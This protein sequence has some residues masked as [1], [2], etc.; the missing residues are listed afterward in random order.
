MPTLLH[1]CMVTGWWNGKYGMQA[2]KPEKLQQ[3]NATWNRNLEENGL[4]ML[5]IYRAGRD[6]WIGE[7]IVYQA[8]HEAMLL[9][10]IHHRDSIS[11]SS[12]Y[13]LI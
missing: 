7:A 6:N 11:K 8:I 9:C 2:S 3:W 10:Y 4:Y 12:N 1:T 13:M 5:L